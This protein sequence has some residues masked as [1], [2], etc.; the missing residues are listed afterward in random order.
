MR[1]TSPSHLVMMVTPGFY[2]FLLSHRCL[3]GG[4]QNDAPRLDAPDLARVL[5]DGAVA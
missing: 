1:V 4:G 2:E 5:L 3:V